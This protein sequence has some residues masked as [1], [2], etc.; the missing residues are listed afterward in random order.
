MRNNCQRASHPAWTIISI[1]I[2]LCHRLII[3]PLVSILKKEN[4]RVTSE[5][6]E[7]LV[8]LYTFPSSNNIKAGNE[9]TNVLQLHIL[10]TSER[11][12]LT[13][14]VFLLVKGQ[15]ADL[16]TCEDQAI[17]R[18]RFIPKWRLWISECFSWTSLVV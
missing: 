14:L 15:M 12:S 1:Y 3:R 17:D 11:V 4:K 8:I 7:W 5:S 18:K 10:V 2:S 13:N 9:P 16:W 6:E